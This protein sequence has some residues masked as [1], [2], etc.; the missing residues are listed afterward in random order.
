MGKYRALSRRTRKSTNYLI[1]YVYFYINFL[2]I[3]YFSLLDE[4]SIR[5]L[6]KTLFLFQIKKADDNNIFSAENNLNRFSFSFE[7]FFLIKKVNKYQKT[8]LL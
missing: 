8:F 5:M 4:G 2:L 7:D 3:F 6:V 1:A